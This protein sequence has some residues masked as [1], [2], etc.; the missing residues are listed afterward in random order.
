MMNQQGIGI[1]RNGSLD[2]RA[3]R[4]HTA[5][6]PAYRPFSVHLQTVWTVV[7]DLPDIQQLV[8]MTGESVGIDHGRLAR[9]GWLPPSAG[10]ADVSAAW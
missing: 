5:D 8:A 9:Y 2:Q 7:S 3:A 6:Q 4:G 1:G 10:H